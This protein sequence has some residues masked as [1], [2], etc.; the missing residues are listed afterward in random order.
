MS[1][2]ARPV[3]LSAI[4][5]YL[6]STKGLR[7]VL[8]ERDARVAIL[9]EDKVGLAADDDHE[10][11]Q[12]ELS[13]VDQQWVRKILLNDIAGELLHKF[14]EIGVTLMRLSSHLHFLLLS[15][16]LRLFLLDFFFY[17]LCCGHL[18]GRFCSWF[19]NLSWNSLYSS[20]LLDS[21]GGSCLGNCAL[22]RVL[23]DLF[24]FFRFQGSLSPLVLLGHDGV[25]VGSWIANHLYSSAHV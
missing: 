18:C 5:Q 20:L 6:T 3:S 23:D 19:F 22:S 16:L 13:I 21:C 4:F 1:N 14:D 7:A 25:F 17:L 24:H 15:L 2:P 8:I 11:T 10:A 9:A 12:V